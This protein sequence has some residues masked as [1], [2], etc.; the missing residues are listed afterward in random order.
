MC[1]NTPKDT[2][3]KKAVVYYGGDVEEATL[4]INLVGKSLG[5][6]FQTFLTCFGL[7]PN[8]SNLQVANYQK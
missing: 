5:P 8:K 1:F 3:I 2:I 7:K 6:L 4:H